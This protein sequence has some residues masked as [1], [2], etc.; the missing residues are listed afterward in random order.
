MKQ[1]M[2]NDIQYGHIPTLAL[3]RNYRII[4]MTCQSTKVKSGA[5]YIRLPIYR[6]FP[7][8][9]IY[10]LAVQKAISFFISP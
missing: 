3:N 2:N 8:I 9:Y 1:D 4:V 7:C 6:V 10:M 5:P